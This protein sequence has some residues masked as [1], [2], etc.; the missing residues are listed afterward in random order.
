MDD[1]LQL[2][3]GQPRIRPKTKHPQ[4]QASTKRPVPDNGVGF[5]VGRTHHGKDTVHGPN[6]K[7]VVKVTYDDGTEQDL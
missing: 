3:Y 7:R 6:G 1:A 2:Q 4:G 5:L